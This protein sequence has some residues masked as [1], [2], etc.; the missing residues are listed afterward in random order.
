MDKLKNIGYGDWF[1]NQVDVDKIAAHDVARVGTLN[2]TFMQS[3][4]FLEA[5]DVVRGQ[6]AVD[7]DLY[8]I[9][10]EVLVVGHGHENR[11]LRIRRKKQLLFE[12]TEF[13]GDVEN[14]GLDFLDLA[15]VLA[16]TPGLK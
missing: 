14:V 3:L 7:L 15:R 8:G 13:R 4:E 10:A 12:I 1:R 2:T 5:I 11:D 6:L 16:Y 9:E